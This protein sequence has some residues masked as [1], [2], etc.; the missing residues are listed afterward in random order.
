VESFVKLRQRIHTTWDIVALLSISHPEE[1]VDW[2]FHRV[3]IP[4]CKNEVDP[5]DGTMKLLEEVDSE[6]MND[7]ERNWSNV[8]RIP[9][10]VQNET[11]LLEIMLNLI[12]D[13]DVLSS[14]KLHNPCMMW[15]TV[16]DFV[17]FGIGTILFCTVAVKCC[18]LDRV[19]R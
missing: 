18:S 1:C 3:S 17:G 13:V 14:Q 4:H 2:K 9:C 8:V 5:C 11:R 16:P 15:G 6:F 12:K 19:P 10:H 7:D